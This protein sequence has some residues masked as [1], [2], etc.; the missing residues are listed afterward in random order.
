VTWSGYTLS[1]TS[2]AV[3]TSAKRTIHTAEAHTQLEAAF[4]TVVITNAS[5]HILLYCVIQHRHICIH[6][7]ICAC[8]RT[9]IHILRTC[10]CTTDMHKH[11]HTHTQIYRL[12]MYQLHTVQQFMEPGVHVCYS[13]DVAVIS[14]PQN[15]VSTS[16][17]HNTG[18]FC[19]CSVLHF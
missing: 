12:K 3:R 14:C 11:T 18:R 1:Q 2:T 10:I 4:V 17:Y 5:R 7:R 19:S 6:Q 16:S 15:V 9:Y 8:M 13:H